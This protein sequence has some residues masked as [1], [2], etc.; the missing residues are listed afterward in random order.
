MPFTL[1]VNLPWLHYGHDF[2]RAWNHM[3][4]ST[5]QSRQTIS[6]ALS[7]AKD[8]GAQVVRWFLFGDGRA[9]KGQLSADFYDDVDAA[10]S[11]CLENDLKVIFVL[12]DYQWFKDAYTHEGVQLFGRASLLLNERERT[13]DQYVRPFLAYVK[14]HPALYLIELMNEPEWL[15]KEQ[16]LVAKPI[17]K[18][19]L[20]ELLHSM[21]TLVQE[22]ALRTTLGCAHQKYFHIF[23]ALGVDV[24]QVHHYEGELKAFE[25]LLGEFS[26]TQQ[27]VSDVIKNARAL[28]FSGAFPWSLLSSDE[29]SDKDKLLLELAAL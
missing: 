11:L 22:F 16:S 6:K 9:L 21:K 12:F 14:D 15:L 28:R 7:A 5:S 27:N 13:F 2:G 19:R 3:G 24:P 26:S 17:D 1:G 23:E 20:F 18:D 4:V 29:H 25:G 10:L 8:A